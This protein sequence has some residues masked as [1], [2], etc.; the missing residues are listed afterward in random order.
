MIQASYKLSK[1][2]AGPLRKNEMILFHGNQGWLS[3][4]CHERLNGMRSKF[5][6]SL[7]QSGN[8]GN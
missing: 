1:G 2:E 6:K 8:A 5:L 7:D 3:Q 4:T